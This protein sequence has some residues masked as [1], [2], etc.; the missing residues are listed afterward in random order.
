MWASKFVSTICCGEVAAVEGLFPILESAL[1]P[2]RVLLELLPL[3][4]L[5]VSEGP[6]PFERGVMVEEQAGEV[7]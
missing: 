1:T 4:T 6:T 2:L 5:A 3:F 7:V